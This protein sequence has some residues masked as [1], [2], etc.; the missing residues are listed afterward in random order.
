MKQ[1]ETKGYG[2]FRKT[3]AYGL[4]CGIT[5]AGALMLGSTAFADDTITLNPAT[6]LTTLQTPPT[7]DQTQLA[8]QAGHQSGEL[9]SDVTSAELEQAVTAAQEAGVDVKQSDKV[10]H[11]SLSAAQTDLEKQTETVREA[12]AKQETNTTAINQALAENKAIDQA[13]RDEK[14]RVDAINAKGEADIKAK[15][16]AGQAQ[17]EA[18]NKQ[19]QEAADAENARLKADYEAKLTEIEHIKAKMKRSASATNK[20]VKRLI[21]LIK[22]LKLPI[23]KS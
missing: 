18:Q 20:L 3:A 15:N 22:Q 6:N 1:M 21:K 4:V 14:A 8:R 5:L 13:N 17:V 12:T 11:D 19:A 2:Y 9:V 16:A 7:A 23:K 10:T